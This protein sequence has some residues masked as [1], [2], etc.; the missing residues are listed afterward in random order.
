MSGRKP[1]ID[2]GGGV[3]GGLLG[4]KD[5]TKHY[6]HLDWYVDICALTSAKIY[7]KKILNTSIKRSVKQTDKKF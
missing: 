6:K 1:L 7:I 5:T 3:G 4:E 2:L